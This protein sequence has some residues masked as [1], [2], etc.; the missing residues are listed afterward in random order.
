[1]GEEGW[2][3]RGEGARG[4]E[5]R[6]RW[7]RGRKESAEE[8]EMRERKKWR[9]KRRRV[10]NREIGR[11]EKRT[12]YYMIYNTQ[13]TIYAYTYTTIEYQIVDPIWWYVSIDQQPYTWDIV[14]R[15]MHWMGSN[16]GRM[17]TQECTSCN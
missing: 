17:L 4:S 2:R 15:T 9:G 14:A 11:E 7:Q 8:E 16:G 10:G 6:A 5:G 3:M 12:M 1:M 13:Y